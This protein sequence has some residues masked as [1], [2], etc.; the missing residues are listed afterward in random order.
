MQTPLSEVPAPSVT[1]PEPARATPQLLTHACGNVRV[2]GQ[3]CQCK[4]CVF[5]NCTACIEALFG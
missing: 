4:T 2:R 3:E 5:E 1:A